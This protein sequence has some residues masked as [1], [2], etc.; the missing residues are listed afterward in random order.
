MYKGTSY[1]DPPHLKDI[2][3]FINGEPMNRTFYR[4]DIVTFNE[5]GIGTKLA[6]CI[7]ELRIW[8]KL[9]DAAT[10]KGNMFLTE[11]NDPLL[12]KQLHFNEGV[13]NFATYGTYGKVAP[14]TS[15][16][17]D[18]ITQEGGHLEKA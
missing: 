17:P 5:A 11:I 2:H 4:K 7:D 10:I 15:I 16:S 9:L 1:I 8:K 13:G 12:K 14:L 3:F 18:R 6:D